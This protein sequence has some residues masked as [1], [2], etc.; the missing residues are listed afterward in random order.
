M[1]TIGSTSTGAIDFIAEITAVG[2]YLSLPRPTTKVLTTSSSAASYPELFIH[3]DSA[4]A[5]VYLACPERR[6][7]LQLDALN[8]RSKAINLA[9]GMCASG[10]VHSFCTN[11]HKAGLVTFD[12]SCLW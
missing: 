11:L 7:E 5:G 2:S 9:G 8:A 10:E 1:A 4:W 6:E 3:V 12:A